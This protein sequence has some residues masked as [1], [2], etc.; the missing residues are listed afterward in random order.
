MNSEKRRQAIVAAA[1]AVAA[2]KGLAATTVRD[3]AQEMGTSSGLIHHYFESMDEL[4]ATVFNEVA[5]ADLAATRELMNRAG[6]PTGRLGAYFAAFADP[7]NDSVHQFWLDAWS[8]AG[9]NHT[10]RE[11]S[12]TLNIEWQSLLSEVIHMGMATGEF[13]SVDS[14]E[15]SWKALSLLDGLSLQVI[16][17]PT[18]LDR[19]EAAR[20]AANSME[21][22]LGL[23]LGTL[24]GAVAADR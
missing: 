6:S 4:L 14:I 16:A 24:S 9:R 18:V 15:V 12:R 20:W 19:G 23:P 22:D 10:I 17:H 13:N 5:S 1:Q 8:E 11:R 2:R 21:L 7:D 3:V